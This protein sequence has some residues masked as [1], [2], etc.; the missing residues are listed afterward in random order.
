MKHMLGR[1]IIYC[2]LFVIVLAGCSSN[3]GEG[4][5]QGIDPDKPV[6]LKVAFINEQMFYQS[7]GNVFSAKYPNVQFEVISTMDAAMSKD[8]T[9]AMI[10]LVDENQP[11]IVVLTASQYEALAADGR[12]YELDSMVTQTG[13]E[14]DQMVEGVVQ[15]LRDAGGGKLY[16]L[17]PTFNTNAL[18]Y[19]KDL[20]AKYGVPEPTDFMTWEEVLKLAARFPTDG[21]DETRIYGL[22]SSM[23]AQDPFQLIKD[24]AAAKGLNYLNAD[25]TELT[26]S[27]LEWREIFRE[28]VEGYQNKT[29]HQPVPQQ[30]DGGMMFSMDSMLFNDG[31]AA[32]VI[33][34]SNMINLRGSMGVR[35][36]SA[37]GDSDSSSSQPEEVNMGVV[38]APVDAA[39]P[40]MTSAY[41]V[42]QIFS[43]NAASSQADMAWA[44][45]QY[46]HGEEAA[47]IRSNTAMDLQSRLGYETT[48]DGVNLEPFY[49]LKPLPMETTHWYPKG[50]RDSF[51]KIAGE[52]ISAASSGGKSV[53]E[54]FDAI[55]SRGADAL[56]EANLSGEK[57]QGGGGG[58]AANFM[59][60]G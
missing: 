30:G 55:T 52:E 42:S 12:L 38:T 39:T 20:F 48:S 4:K 23:F 28:V 60:A 59:F 58:F 37:A 36:V 8:P 51:A 29:I 17:A 11:D 5:P 32:M 35:A 3:N 21:D 16:G 2:L 34:N 13:F 7:Y 9:Q 14:L 15:L 19:N 49:K 46:V 1:G 6:T 54:A 47:K 33:D 41:T 43:I 53:D 18:Y 27:E 44:F 50:F 57:E 56:A 10:D 26:M 22:A 31:R 25:A 24:M 45:I 40:D